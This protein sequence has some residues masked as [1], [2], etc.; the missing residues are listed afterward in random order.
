MPSHPKTPTCA[1]SVPRRTPNTHRSA[2]LTVLSVPL[3]SG[4]P[5]RQRALPPLRRGSDADSPPS[6]C[7]TSSSVPLHLFLPAPETPT[8]A[9][10][11]HS[12][13]QASPSIGSLVR[14]MPAP[15]R[16]KC[17]SQ[18]PYALICCCVFAFPPP[19]DHP[20]RHLSTFHSS[21]LQTCLNRSYSACTLCQDRQFCPCLLAHAAPPPHQNQKRRSN[22]S[23]PMPYRAYV[24][25]YRARLAQ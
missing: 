19:C 23:A 2:L 25:H 10:H 12:F 11:Q 20:P 16:C 8:P 14:R 17:A 24:C 7:C 21:P 15:R 4:W 22:T 18:R 5:A 9:L 1:P 6:L 3:R 13:I